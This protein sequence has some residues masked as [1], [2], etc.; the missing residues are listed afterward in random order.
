[1]S[2]TGGLGADA[3]ID[4]SGSPSAQSNALACIRRHGRVNFVGLDGGDLKIDPGS[5]FIYRRAT[6][7]RNIDFQDKY[8]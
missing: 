1:M 4:Y 8:I 2:I 5:T 7:E 3:A 6:L